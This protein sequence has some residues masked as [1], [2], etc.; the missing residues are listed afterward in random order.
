M[1]ETARQPSG[2]AA[3][4]PPIAAVASLKID[5]ERL[6]RMWAMTP[7][8]RIATAERGQFTLGEMLHWAARRLREVPLLYGE[9]FFITLLSAD[10][11]VGV[12]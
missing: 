1:S 5:P 7:A 4:T 8:E 12:E 3:R 11:A 9:F 2:I 10:A 6:E